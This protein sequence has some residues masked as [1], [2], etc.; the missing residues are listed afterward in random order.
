MPLPCNHKNVNCVTFLNMVF[1]CHGN[2]T[3]NDPVPNPMAVTFCPFFPNW[4]VGSGDTRI[5]ISV[6]CIAS[7]LA[8]RSAVTIY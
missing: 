1:E 7:G 2:K 6:A 5:D 4:R 3:Y 8:I